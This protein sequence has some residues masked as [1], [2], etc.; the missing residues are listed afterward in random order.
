MA[1]A[2]ARAGANS[3]NFLVPSFG[4]ADERTLTD[5]QWAMLP[6]GFLRDF[7]SRRFVDESG[8]ADSNLLIQ[9]CGSVG[10]NIDVTRTPEIPSVAGMRLSE[11]PTDEQYPE[12]P[13]GI[14]LV[15][16]VDV[17]LPN[18]PDWLIQLNV[19]YSASE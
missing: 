4:P 8:E 13:A 7:L 1:I 9:S 6:S 17:G 10:F 18:K 5:V 2:L 19:A 16:V 14:L 11:G 3:A 15:N 12:K